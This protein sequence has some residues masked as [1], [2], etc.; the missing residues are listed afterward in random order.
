LSEHDLAVKRQIGLDPGDAGHDRAR[1]IDALRDA[2]RS[3]GIVV[4]NALSFADVARF[5]ARTPCRLLAVPLEDALGVIDQINMPGTVT[6]H[7]NWM[8]RLPADLE[9]L[10]THENIQR[11][12]AELAAEGRSTRD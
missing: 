2:V 10:G 3:H 7:Q 6:E 1:A 9:D 12:A 4:R 11:L 5:I 8:R